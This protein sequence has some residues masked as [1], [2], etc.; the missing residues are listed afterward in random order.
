M[1]LS[2]ELIGSLLDKWKGGL[3]RLQN[4]AWHFGWGDEFFDGSAPPFAAFSSGKGMM[5]CRAWVL[6]K[7]R[8]YENDSS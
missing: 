4:Q 6:W 7:W 8:H 3:R 5:R 2:K 1:I